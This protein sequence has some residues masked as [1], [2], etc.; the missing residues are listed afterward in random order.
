MRVS[1]GSF[2]TVV[3]YLPFL[4]RV[5]DTYGGSIQITSEEVVYSAPELQGSEGEVVNLLTPIT[6]KLSR[7]IQRAA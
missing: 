5:C 1:I 2:E 6:E 7:K 4:E 3:P